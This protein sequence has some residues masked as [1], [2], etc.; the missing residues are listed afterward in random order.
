M[1]RV[2]IG[3]GLRATNYSRVLPAPNADHTQQ[4][5][6]LTTGLEPA[7]AYLRGR[8]AA[9]RTPLALPAWVFFLYPDKREVETLAKAYF[10]PTAIVMVPSTEHIHS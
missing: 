5:L 3:Y 4:L 2:C 9:S 1:L 10:K 7:H 8:G 6:E